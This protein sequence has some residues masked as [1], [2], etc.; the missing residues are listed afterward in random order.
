MESSQTSP[1]KRENLIF[2][3]VIRLFVSYLFDYNREVLTCPVAYFSLMYYEELMILR[4]AP[5][6]PLFMHYELAPMSWWFRDSGKLGWYENYPVYW[7]EISQVLHPFNTSTKG[8]GGFGKWSFFADVQ[9]CI[10]KVQKYIV[11][12]IKKCIYKFSNPCLNQMIHFQL[13]YSVYL[14]SIDQ[15]SFPWI[16][17][18]KPQILLHQHNLFQYLKCSNFLACFV[19]HC[20]HLWS[21]FSMRM[22]HS[23]DSD[24]ESWVKLRQYSL[25]VF[26]FAKP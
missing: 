25:P 6:W 7:V 11:S 19:Q 21:D 14:L 8:L 13:E 24:F 1:N 12:A 22:T 20:W 18:L 9:Y 16:W 2:G 5:P 17:G 4:G 10:K 26:N 15:V 3:A 23:C